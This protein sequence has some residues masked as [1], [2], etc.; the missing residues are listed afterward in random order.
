MAFQKLTHVS[1]NRSLT[2]AALIRAAT[3]RERSGRGANMS[4]REL[5]LCSVGLAL[6]GSVFVLTG[7]RAQQPTTPPPAAATPRPPVQLSPEA[8]ERQNRTLADHQRLM[9]LLHMTTI[10]RCRDGNN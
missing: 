1:A 2:V 9:D 7:T 8:L 5:I 3:V 6:L 4:T 10:R